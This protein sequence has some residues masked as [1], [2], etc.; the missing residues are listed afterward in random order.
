MP[1]FSKKSL[2]KLATCDRRLYDICSEAIK[3]TDFAVICGH[4]GEADQNAAFKAGTS[5]LKFPMSK[6]NSTPSLAIDIL[7]YPVDW[8][9]IERFKRL[10]I[11]IKK[12][13]SDLNIGIEWG[14]DWKGGFRD[15]PHW[16]LI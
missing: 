4:R 8:D 13:A 1:V 6:H 10:A 12:A 2:D 7:P 5:K 16:Q 15:F 3:H 11:V 9:D 14:G